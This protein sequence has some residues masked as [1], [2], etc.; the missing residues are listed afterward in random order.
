MIQDEGIV[1]TGAG[2][3]SPHPLTGDGKVT[4][5]GWQF[6]KHRAEYRRIKGETSSAVS[7]CALG[8]VAE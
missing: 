8:A 5:A 7:K 3:H 2:T 6:P 4:K 1:S